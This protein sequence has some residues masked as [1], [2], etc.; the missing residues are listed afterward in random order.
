MG[1]KNPLCAF[2]EY[3]TKFSKVKYFTSFYKRFYGQHKIFY[4]FNYFFTYKQT[5]ENE[6]TFFIQEEIYEGLD[7]SFEWVQLISPF[8][9]H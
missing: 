8:H 5:Y 2:G 9:T 1:E 6:K 7:Y 3:F 4:K